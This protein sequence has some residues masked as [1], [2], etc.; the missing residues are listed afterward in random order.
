M[1]LP[2]PNG[3]ALASR[4]WCLALPSR[5]GMV[6]PFLLGVLFAPSFWEFGLALPSRGVVV[7]LLEVVLGPSLLGLAYLAVRGV[8]HSSRWVLAPSFSE[9]SF[10][11]VGIGPV[12]WVWE[13]A[14]PFLVCEF[15]PSLIDS[16]LLGVWW[17]PFPSRG[18]GLG[19]P[20]LGL[21]IARVSHGGGLFFLS[22]GVRP[23]FWEWW[24]ALPSWGRVWP[25]GLGP[26]L[27]WRRFT[28]PSSSG[29]LALLGLG[30]SE[31]CSC[32][33]GMGWPSPLGV[34]VWPFLLEVGL[35]ALPSWGWGWNV[36]LRVGIGP[37]FLV[38]VLALPSNWP[39]PLEMVSWHF[40]LGV[41]FLFFGGGWPFLL[42]LPSCCQWSPFLLGM[43]VGPSR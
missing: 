11:R 13:F 31:G 5:G 21:A 12:F 10:L 8:R 2:S 4:G 6:R 26:S 24:L 18:W 42:A 7:G 20:F 38:W 15:L 39:F 19:F 43:G 16:S 37:V 28:I 33:L 17:L 32:L 30:R 1:V 3:L 22:V 29:S 9:L 34:G 14:L 40:F 25:A 23:P 27:L 36:I 41:V 35:L